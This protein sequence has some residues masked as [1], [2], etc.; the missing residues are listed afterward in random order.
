MISGYVCVKFFSEYSGYKPVNSEVLITSAP[1]VL[2]LTD[3]VLNSLGGI[4]QVLKIPGVSLTPA[5]KNKRIIVMDTLYLL[6]FGPRTGQAA[7]D[8]T[9]KLHPELAQDKVSER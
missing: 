7:L 2:L 9:L 3:R 8:L 1:D 6:G 5:G 4:E